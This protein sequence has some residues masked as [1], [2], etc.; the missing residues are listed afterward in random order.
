MYLDLLEK[1][2]LHMLYDP[3][4]VVEMPEFSREAFR[5]AV[6][7]RAAAA[8]GGGTPIDMR[9]QRSLGRDWPEYAQ[10]MIGV[11]R[12]RNVRRCVQTAID[13]AC[14]GT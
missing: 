13:E 4:D 3:P 11:K 5:G 10:T 8:G 7:A 2:L 1:A 6:E 12:L 14:R 9:S